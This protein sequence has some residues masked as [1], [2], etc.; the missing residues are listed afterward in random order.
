MST[1]KKPADAMGVRG[2]AILALLAT[3]ML[4]AFQ[5]SA[6]VAAPTREFLGSFGPFEGEANGIVGMAVDQET[7]DVFVA[8]RASAAIY[9]FAPEG[10]GVLATI[11][12][13]SLVPRFWNPQG[14]HPIGLAVDNSCYEHQ[15]RLTG[16]ACEEYDP[17]YGDLY[18]TVESAGIQKWR[19][20]GSGYEQLS[21][22]S[23]V[24]GGVSYGVAVDPQGD[25]YEPFADSESKGGSYNIPGEVIEFKKIVEKVINGGQEEF[26]ERLEEIVIP[27]NIV[28]EVAYIAVDGV[29]D[30]YVG[31]FVGE[32]AE[33]GDGG[34]AKVKINENGEVLSE[35]ALMDATSGVYGTVGVDPVTGAVFVG[36]QAAVQ[37][38]SQSGAPGVVFGSEEPLGGSLG[39]GAAQSKAIAVDGGR[40]V[41][42]VGN[43]SLG[44]VD[45]FGPVVGPPTI[46]EAQ[47][48]ASA[49]ARTSALVGGTATTESKRANYYF[50][51]V[52]ADEYE[53][54]AADPYVSGG[55]TAIE[56]L[57]GGQAPVTVERVA[58][59]GLLAGTT[60]HYRM[61]VTNQAGTAYGPD[62]VF[63]TAAPTPP[64]VATGGALEVSATGVTLTGTV[65]PRGLL[66]SYV[67][68]V[69]TDTGYGGARLF[70]NA[71]SSTVEV[72]VS[73]DV[74]FL[75]PGT[76]YHYRLSA[77][78]FD[79]TSYG[80]DGTFT[81]P[82]VAASLAQPVSEPLIATGQGSFPSIA[83]AITKPVGNGK[84]KPSGA[85]RRRKVTGRACGKGGSGKRRTKCQ[86]QA[87]KRH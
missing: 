30:L 43:P 51:Y 81:T 13:T 39:K 8:D 46:G 58:L 50:E 7:G 66:T 14:V 4:L 74:Q 42:Y 25:V 5:A 12:E 79:G 24:L 21:G 16:K 72:P 35:E 22:P 84:K 57:T 38:F 9:E 19:L 33:R 85:H 6:A 86:A 3:L 73:V 82:A 2:T 28:A 32:P 78:S 48:G 29:G 45:M 41:V 49:V 65:D 18:V 62:Q 64:A 71:G 53:P 10:K 26:Q 61:V 34:V 23:S 52:A 47:P 11:S 87:R 36:D 20:G 68:E 44:V 54:G 75:V 83:G 17:S 1:R 67:F 70:G 59:T 55:R 76:T 40:G 80:Q 63:T 27:Q 69:G 56:P 77:T 37:E 15:P 60:Y 31:T